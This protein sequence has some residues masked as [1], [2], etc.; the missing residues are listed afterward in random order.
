[1]EMLPDLM[2]FRVHRVN[3][4]KLKGAK[5]MAALCVEN[6]KKKDS[7]QEAALQALE[8]GT[9]IVL[10]A[11]PTWKNFIRQEF[12][13]GLEDYKQVIKKQKNSPRHQSHRRPRLA[14]HQNSRRKRRPSPNFYTGRPRM[15]RTWLLYVP[16]NEPRQTNW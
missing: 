5:Y 11:Q 1:M 16:G 7:F 6:N 10:K 4:A 13:I 8:A 15:A 3:Q 14:S 2:G 9:P 12:V